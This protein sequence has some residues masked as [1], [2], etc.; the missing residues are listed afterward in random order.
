MGIINS[1]PQ[2]NH[3]KAS[4]ATLT[5][6]GWESNSDGRYKQSIF[7]SG[8]T[9]NTPIIIVDA[10]LSG[11]DIEADKSILEAWIKGPS[12]QKVAQGLN[13]LTF[14]TVEIP[15]VDIPIN[16]GVI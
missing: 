15:E 8:V 12:S 10:R 6:S 1:I 2:A 9:I 11:T 7:V 3:G 5:I 16:I 14:Y 4:S 13:S